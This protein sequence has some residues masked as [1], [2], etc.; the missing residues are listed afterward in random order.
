MATV[1]HTRTSPAVEDFV[2]A[3]Y[4]I[5]AHGDAL[6]STSALARRLHMT[7]AS[8]CGMAKKLAREGFVEHVPYHGVRLTGDGRRVALEVVRHHRLLE[9][10]LVQELGVPLD[11]AHREAETLEHALSEDVE[12]RIAAKLGHPERDP[13]GSPIPN[14]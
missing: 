5:T 11:H 2:K 13:H 12:R 6:A 10:Y 1:D 8:A 9:L 3:V 4:S 7:P 14:A